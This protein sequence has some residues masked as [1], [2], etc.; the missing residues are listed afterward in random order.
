M[1]FITTPA[2]PVT[3]Q[4]SGQPLQVVQPQPIAPAP[5][6]MAQPIPVQEAEM[7]NAINSSLQQLGGTPATAPVTQTTTPAINGDLTP[8]QTSSDALPPLPEI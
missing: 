7:Q 6:A 1:P 2:A 8:P 3:P 4:P 5:V